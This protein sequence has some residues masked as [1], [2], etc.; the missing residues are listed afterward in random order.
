MKFLKSYEIYIIPDDLP[1]KGDY[2]IIRDDALKYLF[3]FKR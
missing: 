2:V 3:F 1:K